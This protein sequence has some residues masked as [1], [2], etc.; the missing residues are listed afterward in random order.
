MTVP[1]VGCIGTGS[2]W[3]GV[4]PQRH[5][6]WRCAS[7][8]ATWTR[9]TPRRLAIASRRL[10]TAM[11]PSMK[12]TASCSNSNDIEIVTIVTPD[13]WHTKIAIDAMR[14]GKDVYCEK[15]LDADH[16]RGQAD[17]QGLEGNRSRLP[18]RHAAAQRN[19]TAVPESGGPDCERDDSAR[20]RS[21]QCA[22]G[23]PPTSGKL[24]TTEVPPEL[25]LGNVAGT[26]AQGRTTSRR[27]C[28]YEFRWWYEYS[29]GKMTDWGAHHVDIAQWGM[30]MSE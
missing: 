16:R 29:G 14:A 26:G 12:T 15:P 22:I 25:E 18:G 28:H 6:V 2:R 24:E 21:V 13:H 3:D 10:R 30:G 11:S 9:N 17:Q 1:L 19:G 20:S 23:A 5:E 27:R 8:C 4:G 7:R